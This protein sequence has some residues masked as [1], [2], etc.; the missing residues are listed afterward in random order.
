MMKL[1]GIFVASLFAGLAYAGGTIGG[2][3]GGLTSELTLHVESL[4]KLFIDAQSFRRTKARLSV[5]STESATAVVVDGDTI[6]VRKIADHLV[7]SDLSKEILPN[8]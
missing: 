2:G 6:E 5:D 3:S 7:N 4:P 8:P 1:L